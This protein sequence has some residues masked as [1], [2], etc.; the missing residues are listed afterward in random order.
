M[1]RESEVSSNNKPDRKV[2]TVSSRNPEMTKILYAKFLRLQW[3]GHGFL[4]NQV[5]VLHGN[6]KRKNWVRQNGFVT[7]AWVI[8]FTNSPW[9]AGSCPPHDLF[10]E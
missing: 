6:R 8:T 9:L 7:Q 4:R 1:H 3:N 10:Q 5:R 2:F